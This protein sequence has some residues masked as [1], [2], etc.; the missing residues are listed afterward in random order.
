MP[1]PLGD[2]CMAT[3]ALQLLKA[4][5]PRDTIVA[6][7]RPDTMP[8][9]QQHPAIDEL[10]AYSS[11]PLLTG[12][13]QLRTLALDEVWLL[14]GSFR[15]ALGPWLARVPRRIG[16]RRDRRGLLLSKALKQPDRSA[17]VSTV[18]WYLD[19]IAQGADVDVPDPSPP[20]QIVVTDE[21]REAAGPVL[22][23]AGKAF[24][25]LVPGAN[26]ADKQWPAARFG[27]LATVLHTM[28]SL[29]SVVVGAPGEADIA[30]AVCK[31]CESDSIVDAIA[32]GTSV[33]ALKALIQAASVVVTNDTGP[34]HIAL[35]TRTP[36]VTLFG[37]TDQRWTV[38]ASALERRLV[39]AP[40]LPE[41][42]MADKSP[43]ACD[44]DRIAVG[45]VRHAVA[46]L[47]GAGLVG[48]GE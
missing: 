34:R 4:A 46:A 18:S 31:A 8:L 23:A 20:M 37:P 42:L 11:R 43:A 17:P 9:L 48:A 39:A 33:G 15:S 21:D 3:P 32:M 27:K 14:P 16:W 44:M 22:E 38:M 47:V 45:D 1:K 2:V 36:V 7:A 25:V 6:L 12:A 24:A 35:C 19:L 5:R 13:R 10:H 26:R 29:R 28:Y 41:H 40:F 30:A